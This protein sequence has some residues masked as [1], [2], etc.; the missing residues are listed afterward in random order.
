[1]PLDRLSQ[2]DE[3]ERDQR[4]G[5]A[6]LLVHNEA[7]L[8]C[9]NLLILWVVL[10]QAL[11]FV[12]APAFSSPFLYD[13]LP[14]IVYNEDFRAEH[15]VLAILRDHPTATQFDRRPIGGIISWLNFEMFGLN[16]SAFRAVN[17]IIHWLCAGVLIWLIV[18]CAQHFNI[19]KPRLFATLL[20]S[21]WALHPIHSSAVIYIYQRVESLMTLFFL[22]SCACL[23]ES[24][25]SRPTSRVWWRL[26]SA[27]AA[28]FCLFSKENGIGLIIILLC[29]DR[30]VLGHSWQRVWS[31]HKFF[32]LTLIAIWFA[33]SLI[34][35]SGPLIHEW[36]DLTSLAH[37]WIYFQTEC[38]VVFN[39]F[40]LLIWPTPLVFA[41]V[42]RVAESLSDW[43]P[44]LAALFAIFVSVAWKARRQSW[45]WLPLL[46]ILLVLAPTSSFVPVPLEPSFDYRMHLPAS[47][48]LAILLCAGW[49]LSKRL[50]IS[51][52]WLFI[53][54]TGWLIFLG[55]TTR[56]RAQDYARSESIWLDTVLKEPENIKAWFNLS[57]FLLGEGRLE[58]ARVA[59]EA[60]NR[61]NQALQI[62]WID[63]QYERILGL[64]AERQGAWNDAERHY[65]SAE[66][67]LPGKPEIRIG[68]A[69]ALLHLDQPEQALHQLTLEHAPGTEPIESVVLRGLAFA[70]LGRMDEA[71]QAATQSIRA[72][73]VTPEIESVRAELLNELLKS[74]NRK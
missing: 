41:P 34:I 40:R 39:Y 15:P 18:R 36:D 54:V 60:A 50:E 45:L 42:P 32:Y 1:M 38:R 35:L 37:P 10:F 23:L 28:C 16:V 30:I 2:S 9:T 53:A 29:I 49:S 4:L 13:D 61:A 64:I 70:K 57:L 24:S 46:T 63:A 69:R 19:K 58:E 31:L 21:I 25:A 22:L 62:L 33:F 59:A 44:Y 47:G 6:P 27:M 12:Y 8:S 68:L 55:F 48:A 14:N 20:A 26:G 17:L 43:L 56:S 72:R 52:H 11:A 74:E 65:R 5:D 67:K 73:A 3:Y 66:D 71:R 51:A 7:M